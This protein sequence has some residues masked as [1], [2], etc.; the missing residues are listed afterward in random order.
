M[1]NIVKLED[2]MAFIEANP[3]KHN[4]KYWAQQT[5]CSTSYCYAGLAIAQ[6][7]PKAKFLFYDNW[8]T[9]DPELLAST[10]EINGEMY[11]VETLASKILELDKKDSDILFDS[12]NSV[13]LL[14]EMVDALKNG[15]SL[16][17]HGPTYEQD[18]DWY[19]TADENYYD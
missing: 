1:A 12:D 15:E 9:S 7:Y 14:R 10:V 11:D 4:Q 13:S 2:T 6:E 17:V 8:D 18:E 5:P 19:W 16:E 3:E